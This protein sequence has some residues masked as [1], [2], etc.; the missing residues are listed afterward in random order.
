MPNERAK[1]E[2]FLFIAMGLV[3]LTIAVALN[4]HGGLPA[5]AAAPAAVA[6]FVVVL[7][8][9]ILVWRRKA[10]EGVVPVIANAP[11][12]ASAPVAQ[13]PAPPATPPAMPRS[14]EPTKA[15]RVSAPA[16]TAPKAASRPAPATPAPSA[17]A[18]AAHHDRNSAVDASYMQELVS[19]LSSTADDD[20]DAPYL[21]PK[22]D[23]ADARS[24][25]ADVEV[26]QDAIKRLLAEVNATERKDAGQPSS[27]RARNM[28]ADRAATQSVE[29]LRSAA[30]VMRKPDDQART[31]REALP[32]SAVANTQSRARGSIHPS[33]ARA[34]VLS[35]AISAGRID[36]TLEPILGLEDQKTRHYEVAVRLRDAD[37]QTLD[38]FGEGP[39][40][41]GTGLLPLFDSVSITRVAAVARRLDERGKGGSVF[42]S[43]NGESIADER[44]VGELAETLHQR[45]S[46]ATQLVLSFSQADVRDF[47]T[48]EWDSLADMRALGF[49]FA[50]SN[51]TDMDMDFETLAEQG[52]TFAKLDAETFLSGLRDPSGLIPARD[53]CRHLAKAGLTLVVER[54]ESDDQLARIFGFGVLLGQGQLFG[55]ARPVRADAIRPSGT[56]A[57]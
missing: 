26:I 24:R 15:A 5:A 48:P 36:V 32:T 9:H 27:Q 34:R 43:F 51:L 10:A 38:V 45:A 35:D 54:I 56:A 50:I 12:A 11:R 20:G 33:E 47:S 18:P 46:L 2:T 30:D 40:L 1:A 13:R 16:A 19:H 55:G 42:S 49:R 53:V 17:P 31:P 52:F 57:A 3:S 23:T 37:G 21:P 14:A 6:V 28:D 41:R 39:D 29:A 8:L 4:Q 7:S 22:A 25:E 44:F